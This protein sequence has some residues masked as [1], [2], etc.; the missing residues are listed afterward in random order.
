MW[1]PDGEWLVYTEQVTIIPQGLEGS[2]DCDEYTVL[3]RARAD[4]ATGAQQ[5]YRSDVNVELAT[6][7]GWSPDGS[8]FIF[9]IRPSTSDG[10]SR[11]WGPII[12]A[13]MDGSAV[14]QSDASI[15]RQEQSENT[16]SPDKSYLAITQGHSLASWNDKSV[17]IFDPS[18]G[19][20][21]RLSPSSLA[22]IS[23]AWSPS[24]ERIAFAAAPDSPQYQTFAAAGPAL[25][26]RRIWVMNR[27]GSGSRQLTD[28]ARYR[29]EDP[30]WSADGTHILFER[31][32][33]QAE[34]P[35]LSVWLIDV[36]TGKL[37]EVMDGLEVIDNGGYLWTQAREL[38]YWR[39]P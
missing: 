37:D 5:I 10:I 31:V 25:A 8:Y 2:C 22:A 3:Y 6:W 15:P 33:L 13:A 35:L 14:I 17:S 28:D 32:D 30:L 21:T 4:G 19:H 34:T 38:D 29:D 12:A 7:D 26:Q 27:D 1:S 11:P 20:T 16:A 23:P 24:G 18:V 39:W 9:S 36:A